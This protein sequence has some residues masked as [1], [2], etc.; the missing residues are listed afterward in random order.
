MHNPSPAHCRVTHLAATAALMALSG[1]GGG[2]SSST[3][4]PAATCNATAITAYTAVGGA[5]TQTASVTASSGTQVTLSPEP[6]SG[7]SWAWSGCGTSGSSRE[8]VFTPTAPCSATAV[9]T[10]SCGATSNQT[11]TVTFNAVQAG[12]YPNYN[13]SPPAPDSSGMPSTATQL[14]A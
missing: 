5:R 2:G 10:N 9:H 12:P 8:Q 14:A 1:C 13:V 6:A 7:G 3:P 11:F 4:P